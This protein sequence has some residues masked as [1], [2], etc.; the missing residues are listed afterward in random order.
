MLLIDW[1]RA[2]TRRNH[3]LLWLHDRSRPTFVLC[4][5]S[6]ARTAGTGTLALQDLQ[7]STVAVLLALLQ[8]VGARQSTDEEEDLSLPVSL[9]ADLMLAVSIISM[10]SSNGAFKVSSPAE[11]QGLPCRP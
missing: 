5:N 1:A 8:V 11:R 3:L 6:E 9:D 7:L 2:S 10:N 4:Q